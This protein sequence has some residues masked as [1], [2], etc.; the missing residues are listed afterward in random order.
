MVRIILM[1]AVVE[2]LV[3]L[4]LMLLLLVQVMVV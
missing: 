3:Q 2:V 4:V 1:G